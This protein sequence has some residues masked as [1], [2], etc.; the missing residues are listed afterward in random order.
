[1]ALADDLGAESS[2]S[3]LAEELV[4][5][6]LDADF[7]LDLANTLDSNIASFL[8]AISNLEG[9]NTLVKEL[10]SLVK[11]GTSENYDTCGAITD[12]IVLRLRELYEETSSLVLDLHLFKNGGT[13]VGNDNITIGAD[14]HLVH[15]PWAKGCPDSS[16]Y[17][18][19]CGNIRALGFFAAI[20][21]YILF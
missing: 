20:T 4:V 5:I 16:G 10:L 1:M 8:K 9:V 13:I 21:L 15:S 14:K 11:K 2:D 3:T 17:C 12:L 6:L 19:C 18:L 7:F